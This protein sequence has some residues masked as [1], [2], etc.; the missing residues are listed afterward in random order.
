MEAYRQ[1]ASCIDEKNFLYITINRFRDRT[2]MIFLYRDYGEMMEF[3]D[4]ELEF[5]TVLERAVE[6]AEL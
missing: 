2:P 5:R 4:G 6:E 3:I 1:D